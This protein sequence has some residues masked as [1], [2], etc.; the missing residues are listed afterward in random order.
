MPATSDIEFLDYI[1]SSANRLAELS[2]ENKQLRTKVAELSE[3]KVILEKV[4][5]A[6][7]FDFSS[8][9]GLMEKLGKSRLI[10]PLQTTKVAE[11]ISEDPSMLIDLMHKIADTASNYSVGEGV[12]SDTPVSE[13]DPDGWGAMSRRKR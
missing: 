5:S 7:V 6:P 8:V 12:S 2:D 1:D 11:V 10:D 9:E 4:A 3:E 13:S